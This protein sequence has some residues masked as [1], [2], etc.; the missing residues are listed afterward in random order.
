MKAREC[1]VRSS[2]GRRSLK[3]LKYFDALTSVRDIMGFT[4]RVDV[5]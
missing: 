3:Q 1:N 4:L 5:I 2:S